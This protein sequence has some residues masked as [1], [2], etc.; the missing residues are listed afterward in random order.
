ML[1]PKNWGSFQHYKDRSPAWIKLHRGLLDDYTF[2]RLPVASRALAPL[3]WLLA[4]EYEG[5][6]ITASHEELSFRLRMTTKEL[7]DALTPLT[8]SGFFLASG[9]LAECK[10]DACLEKRERRGR[11]EK[12]IRDLSVTS[13]SFEKFKVEY[14]KRDGAQGWKPAAKLFDAAIQSGVDEAR[15]IAGARGYRLEC[16]RKGIVKTDKVAQALTWMRQGRW[17]EHQEQPQTTEE[18]S[19]DWDAQVQRFLR[20]LPWSTKWYGPEPGQLGCRVPPEIL[21]K[22]GVLAEDRKIF[23]A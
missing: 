21:T 22:H 15:I 12:N 18:F 3:L 20:G 8:D 5:G 19:V 17:D 9:V 16:E 11:E 13:A 4:S 10:Q 1:T 6:E 7:V 14:P 2:S 23:A